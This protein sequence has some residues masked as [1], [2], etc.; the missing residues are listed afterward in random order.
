MP[1]RLHKNVQANQQRICA[2]KLSNSNSKEVRLGTSS[3][4]N[5]CKMA[6]GHFLT[7]LNIIIDTA[8][9]RQKRETTPRDT[10]NRYRRHLPRTAPEL[11]SLT[12][13]ITAVAR[14]PF[15]NEKKQL[16]PSACGLQSLY[17]LRRYCAR[18]L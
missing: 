13:G 5:M 17:R 4:Y 15:M 16:S 6:S 1:A 9:C 18:A 10:E 7:G 14:H 12:S 11:A 8:W 3:D 2:F